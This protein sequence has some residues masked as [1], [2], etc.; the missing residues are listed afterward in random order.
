MDCSG[1]VIAERLCIDATRRR[2]RVVFVGECRDELT[3]KVS[4]DM[5][6]KGLTVV[7]TWLYN[8]G[9][10]P[11]VMQVIRESPLIDLLISHRLPMS[12]IQEGFE[13]LGRGEGA[14]VVVDPWQ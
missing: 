2:G 7:G 5:I 1:N 11:T 12:R 13:T 6:R 4:P 10:Y 14:K 8:R 3:L 9:D